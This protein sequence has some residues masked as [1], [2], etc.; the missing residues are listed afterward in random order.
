MSILLDDEVVTIAISHSEYKSI[1]QRSNKMNLFRAKLSF[2]NKLLFFFKFFGGTKMK[3]EELKKRI[4]QLPR[5]G[6]VIFISRQESEELI[7]DWKKNFYE[8]YP[9]LAPKWLDIEIQIR[10]LLSLGL[11]SYSGISIEIK[12][13]K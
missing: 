1:M 5:D 9:L 12:E 10:Y 8:E 7:Q 2:K 4:H 3:F 13:R 6:Q 11:L